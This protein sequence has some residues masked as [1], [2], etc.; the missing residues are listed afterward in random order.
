MPSSLFFALLVIIVGRIIIHA[1]LNDIND[2]HT[3]TF[4]S[5]ASSSS[6]IIL[7]LPSRPRLNNV[8]VSTSVGDPLS[9]F[10]TWIRGIMGFVDCGG[11]PGRDTPSLFVIH[12]IWCVS[13]LCSLSGICGTLYLERAFEITCE[14]RAFKREPIR[15]YLREC[16]GHYEFIYPMT[17]DESRFKV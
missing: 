3:F 1:K 12:Y 7:F 16:I 8:G 6:G 2:A 5:G 9:I 4:T 14:S 10:H 11:A 17:Y 15:T 13:I